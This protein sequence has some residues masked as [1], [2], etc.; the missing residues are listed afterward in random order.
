MGPD[1]GAQ[2][3]QIKADLTFILKFYVDFKCIELILFGALCT[4]VNIYIDLHV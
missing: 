4:C 2:K 3:I 1:S